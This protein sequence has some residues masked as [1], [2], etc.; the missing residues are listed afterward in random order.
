MIKISILS[1]K[2]ECKLAIKK[3]LFLIF[4]NYFIILDNIYNIG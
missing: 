3:K 1:I 2:Y 4:I